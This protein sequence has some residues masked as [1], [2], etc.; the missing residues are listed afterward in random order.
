MEMPASEELKALIDQMPD[1]DRRGM[2][3][4]IEEGKVERAIAEI[5]KGGRDNV[6]GI[7]DMLVEP[8]K[9]NDV[10]PHYALH[11]LAVHVCKLEDDK[12]RR[13]FAEA[14]ASQLGG[15]RPKGVEK[16]LIEQLQVAG[17]KE[18]VE[19]LGK[20]LLDPELCEPAAR[21]LV[22]IG[23][24]AAEQL[25]AALP[26]VT[27][28][29]RL[30]VVQNL[31]VARG[32][33]AVTALKQ[34][35]GDSDSD[36]RIAAAWAL[37]N[38]GDAGSADLVLKAADTHQ[39]WERIQETKACLLLAENLLAAGNKK[40]AAKIYTHLRDTRTDDAERYIREAAEQALAGA[41]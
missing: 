2:Y 38:I 8:G 16:Y 20:A 18:V 10:K 12:P 13:E 27:G 1:P 7:I 28:K 30:T 4:Q 11:A 29:C 32:A 6:L 35:V 9:G 21:A 37:A 25:A 5:H 36:I 31:G 15:K 33:K 23:D 34:A 24:G 40:E 19:A 3:G 22:A 14:V 41:K 39:D 17:G 26:K